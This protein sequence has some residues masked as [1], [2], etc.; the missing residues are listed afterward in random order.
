MAATRENL[1]ATAGAMAK[2]ATA[3]GARGRPAHPGR[4]VALAHLDAHPGD[5]DGAAAASG[6]TPDAIRRWLRAAGRA[7][8][9]GARGTDR[10]PRAPRRGDKTARIAE[11]I[12]SCPEE[13]ADAIGAAVGVSGARVRQV[14][15]KVG[16]D[17]E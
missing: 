7:R 9:V 4:A 3:A 14:R 6:A 17:G 8:P 10:A 13:S 5:L 2:G 15:A 12:L 16:T 11:M 1:G